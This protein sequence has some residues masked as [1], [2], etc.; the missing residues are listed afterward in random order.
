MFN[1]QTINNIIGHGSLIILKSNSKQQYTIKFNALGMHPH[2]LN[3]DNEFGW[4]DV[5]NDS[6]KLS[7]TLNA[8]NKESF[9]KQKFNPMNSK[10]TVS[11]HGT[12]APFMYLALDQLIVK[13]AD[14][15]DTLKLLRLLGLQGVKFNAYDE[16]L[17]N[18]GSWI[19]KSLTWHETNF[20]YA[21]TP[22]K[23]EFFAKFNINLGEKQYEQ[24][25]VTLPESLVSAYP[26][27]YWR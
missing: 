3:I 24:D 10:T 26:V 23:I 18:Y 11:I 20:Q 27:T 21:A 13:Q 25:I 1:P 12:L 19:L 17:N 16:S 22:A 2:S 6:S 4:T 14:P 9:Q 15:F 7:Y 5:N 8:D